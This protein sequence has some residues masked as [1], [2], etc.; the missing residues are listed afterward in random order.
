M[1]EQL[2]QIAEYVA[3]NLVEM[4]SLVNYANYSGAPMMKILNLPID[5][6]G[7]AYDIS[8]LKLASAVG[9]GYYVQAQLVTRKDVSGNSLIPFNSTQT[10]LTIITDGDGSLTIGGETRTI[11]YSGMVYG[12]TPDIVVWGWKENET[13]MWAG[14][15]VWK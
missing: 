3:V 7:R 2:N 13:N 10:H 15:G 14:I 8:L 9:Q 6:G 12:G 1:K 11:K 5:L 4:T